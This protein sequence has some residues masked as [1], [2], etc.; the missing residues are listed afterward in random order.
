MPRKVQSEKD[1]INFL[2]DGTPELVSKP[3]AIRKRAREASKS[4]SLRNQLRNWPATSLLLLRK[5]AARIA[6]AQKRIW[7]KAGC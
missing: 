5:L 1:S 7:P 4:K 6:R 3:F 2:S